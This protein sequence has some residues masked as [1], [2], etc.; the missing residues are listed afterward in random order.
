MTLPA[1]RTAL[2]RRV[3]VQLTGGVLLANLAGAVVLFLFLVF[4]LPTAVPAAD[5]DRLRELNIVLFAVYL[6]FTGLAG[7]LWGNRV[8]RGLR[9]W[10][11]GQA[12]P[13]AALR[14]QVLRAPLRLALVTASFWL[15]AVV[16][17]GGLNISRSPALGLQVASTLL[18]GGATTAALCY[19]L[20]E[21]VLRPVVTLAQQGEFGAPP[22]VAG[23]TRRMVLTWLV[24]SGVPLF[25]IGL[26]YIRLPGE[27]PLTTTAGL[28][29]VGLGLLVGLLATVAAARAVADPIQSVAAALRA[30]AEGRYDTVVPVYDASEIGQLQSG[31]NA[32]SRGLAERERLRDL[33]GRQVGP[34]V[35]RLVLDTGVRLGGERRD[36]AVLFVDVVGS[37]RLAVTREPED[38]VRQLNDFF[39][40]VV[41]AVAR[42]GGWVN[43]FEGDA[44]L[45]VF[46]AP[47][48]LDG[49]RGCALAAARDIA[50]G[51][52]P[53]PLE[54]AIGVSAGPV[55][56]GH[57]G[58]ERR[59]EYTVV[60]DPVNVAARLSE[61]ARTVPG[62]VLADDAV[63][64]AAGA[65]QQRWQAW[66][67]PVVLRGRTEVTALQ[68]PSPPVG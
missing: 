62:R 50:D 66:G 25:G 24:G 3:T 33:F 56:A 20:A 28:F 55:V 67:E 52:G 12:A 53:L 21:R 27:P 35:A 2:L 39:T 40:V 32:M 45:C 57:V 5:Q 44:A 15:G 30:V 31:F 8:N 41:E 19:L 1:D 54:A 11:R 17:F 38:V 18:L 48:A 64:R 29:L 60:G 68:R 42:H 13:T 10:L 23:V 34:D 43:K 7:Q 14:S 46:G 16:L 65:E 4:I 6:P 9:E 26:G 59:F 61:L 63:V 37:T 36:V 58:A 22:V 47:T 51:L 49:A